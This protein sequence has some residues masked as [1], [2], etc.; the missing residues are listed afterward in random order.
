M[1]K[2]KAFIC[3]LA[4]LVLFMGCTA[5][6]AEESTLLVLDDTYASHFLAAG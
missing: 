1:N 4:A 3:A 6:F 5:C 2:I